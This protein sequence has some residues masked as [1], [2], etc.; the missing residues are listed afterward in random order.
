VLAMSFACKRSPPP[1]TPSEPAPKAI[2]PQG[3][4]ADRFLCEDKHEP[5]RSTAPCETSPPVAGG[6]CSN[7]RVYLC[8]HVVSGPPG[9]YA[10]TCPD[11]QGLPNGAVRVVASDGS[12]LTEG[13]CRHGH[14]IG[15]WFDWREGQL[16][17]AIAVDGRESFGLGVSLGSDGTY[18]H[19]VETSVGE[20][21][22]Q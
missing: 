21:S 22:G 13:A 15:I 1:L 11:E 14:A 3:R 18:H 7:E 10:L 12:V 2:P 9:S 19:R 16:R 6:P 8:D 4:T 17:S 20:G 5:Q